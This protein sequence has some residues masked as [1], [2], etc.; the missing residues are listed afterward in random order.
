[1]ENLNSVNSIEYK[2]IMCEL[3]LMSTHVSRPTKRSS[4]N[5]RVRPYVTANYQIRVLYYFVSVQEG[6]LVKVYRIVARIASYL[7]RN[8]RKF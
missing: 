8:R 7:R 5:I 3:K 1:M 2:Y 4:E 6:S